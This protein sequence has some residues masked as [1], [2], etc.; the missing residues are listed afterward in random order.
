MTVAATNGHVQAQPQVGPSRY[1]VSL[2]IPTLNEAGNVT[3]LIAQLDRAIHRDLPSEIV[4][5]DDSTD[6]TP[7][8]WRRPREVSDP[9]SV[10][11]RKEGSEA[12]AA[13]S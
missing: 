10:Q 8:S 9:V 2:V 12:S 11:H 1:A 6:D 5:V 3:E 4:F 13:R 7:L